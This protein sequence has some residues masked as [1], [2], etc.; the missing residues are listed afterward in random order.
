MASPFSVLENGKLLFTRNLASQI[1]LETGNEIPLNPQRLE[2]RCYFKKAK[3]QLKEEQGTDDT[4]FSVEGYS[5]DPVQL[6]EW[7]RNIR[8]SVPCSIDGIGIGSFRWEH[9]VIVAKSLVESVTG[10]ILQGT[11]VV[12]GGLNEGNS[13]F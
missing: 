1:D 2:V 10:T 8:Q 13:L 6:P 3:G 7:A 11:F 12:D 4:T 9:K 5:I